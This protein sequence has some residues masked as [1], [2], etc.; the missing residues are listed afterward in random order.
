MKFAKEIII[1]ILVVSIVHYKSKKIRVLKVCGLYIGGM[2]VW[3]RQMWHF[4]TGSFLAKSDEEDEDDIDNDAVNINHD[5][6][7]AGDGKC[8]TL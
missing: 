3:I 7:N 8:D 4:A 5:I 6:D 1:L 2:S